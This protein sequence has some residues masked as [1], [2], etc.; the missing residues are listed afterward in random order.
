MAN[1]FL[2]NSFRVGTPERGGGDILS[3]L[4]GINTNPDVQLKGQAAGA[5]LGNLDSRTR[6]SNILG[7][8]DAIELADMQELRD[9]F[10]KGSP[11]RQAVIDPRFASGQRGLATRTDRLNKEDSLAKLADSGFTMNIN[12]EQIPLADLINTMSGA[13]FKAFATTDPTVK[14]LLSQKNARDQE[15]AL[16]QILLGSQGDTEKSRKKYIDEQVLGAK[17][18]KIFK[19]E[20]ASGEKLNTEFLRT[21]KKIRLALKKGEAYKMDG[22]LKKLA[23]ELGIKQNE[24]NQLPIK[25]R[26]AYL[27]MLESLEKI[28]QDGGIDRGLYGRIYL[29]ADDAARRRIPK[30]R[31]SSTEALEEWE[32]KVTAATDLTMLGY[33]ASFGKANADFSKV[34]GKEGDELLNSLIATMPQEIKAHLFQVLPELGEAGGNIDKGLE[35]DLLQEAGLK[36][37]PIQEEQT[38]LQSLGLDGGGAR[39]LAS[40]IQPPANIQFQNEGQTEQGTLG[41]VNPP[42]GDPNERLLD[43]FIGQQDPVG[44]AEANLQ[45]PAVQP[46]APKEAVTLQT[47]DPKL[48]VSPQL[49]AIYDGGKGVDKMTMEAERLLK[50]FFD[51]KNPKDLAKAKMIL[52][53]LAQKRQSQL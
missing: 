1:G 5:R 26:T 38:I 14:N 31:S 10:V 35:F 17:Q 41:G 28:K 27:G 12:G 49:E 23:L 19:R 44:R 15:T 18:D 13:D 21:T 11:E 52:K 30:P 43:S 7:Q 36:E 24:L 46:Q 53:F 3:A 8:Q 39:E 6:R 16:R 45:T 34:E 29:K 25:N 37:P 9:Q 51:T 50:Q 42:Q 2:Q 48:V 20:R 40:G 47:T 4:L 22:D 33:I 32:K